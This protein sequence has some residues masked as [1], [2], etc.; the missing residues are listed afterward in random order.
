[1]CANVR[2][3]LTVLVNPPATLLDAFAAAVRSRYRRFTKRSRF[4]VQFQLMRREWIR[5]APYLMLALLSAGSARAQTYDPQAMTQPAMRPLT[6]PLVVVA[7]PPRLQ[8]EMGGGFIEF[9]FGGDQRPVAVVP[10]A[11][12]PP[13]PRLQPAPRGYADTAPVDPMLEQRRPDLP[14]DPKFLPQEVAYRGKEGPGTIVVDTP[15][16]FLY[17]VGEGGTAMRYGVG[18][19]RD[20][21]DWQ[22][23][24][25]I[26]YKRPWP[27]WTPPAEMIVRQPELEPYRHGMEP[28]LDNP[29]GARALYIFQNGRDTLYR[30]HG[31]MDARSIGQAVSSG[32]VRLLF[33]DVIDLYSR[34]PDGSPI[35]VWQ[36]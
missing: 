26:A 23:R 20:G 9:L 2:P 11:V 25:T 15:N 3:P 14:M 12:P 35:V 8:S 28:G 34:V 36:A 6:P 13:Q 33:Q 17:L 24:G 4:R 31:N 32:C 1:V 21:F 5:I 29:L 27:R 19:G 7:Q 10:Y 22:G 16:R 30:L 18:V